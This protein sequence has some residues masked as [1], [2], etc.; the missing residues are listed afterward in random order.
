MSHTGV[1]DGT[2]AAAE[3]ARP[4]PRRWVWAVVAVSAVLVALGLAAW[5]VWWPTNVDRRALDRIGPPVPG[6]SADGADYVS[7]GNTLCFDV[8][9]R[10]KR[11][12]TVPPG[13]T[14]EAALTGAVTAARSAGYSTVY[15]PS[16]VV[17]PTSRRQFICQV[18]AQD[19][20][21]DINIEITAALP[22]ASPAWATPGGSIRQPPG[23]T[24][25]DQVAVSAA[26]T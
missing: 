17:G 23:E 16:C 18:T 2:G 6:A 21:I 8:C 1:N 22:E 4:R 14:L 3:G 25:V 19:S 7:E 5:E 24:P 15:R 26:L 9:T 10:L 11:I 20:D 13:T 12:Y